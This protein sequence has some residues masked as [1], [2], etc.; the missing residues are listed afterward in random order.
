[1]RFAGEVIYCLLAG[2]AQMGRARRT[3]K[4]GR[5]FALV[6]RTRRKGGIERK[7]LI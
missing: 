1:M 7:C 3:V 6:N 5:N 4:V 2:G